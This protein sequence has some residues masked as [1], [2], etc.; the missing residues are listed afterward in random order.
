MSRETVEVVR[1]IYA[2]WESGEPVEDLVAPDLE[3][4]NPPYAV[5]SGTTRGRDSLDGVRDVYPDFRVEVEAFIDAGD[6]VVM[7]GTAS[8]TAASGVHM[9][10]RQGC[11]WTVEDGKAVRFQW[12]NEPDEALEAAGLKGRPR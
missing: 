7:I 8:G 2:A 1:A 6:K 11:V 9:V 3:Y 10:W 12:F 4:V 5:E